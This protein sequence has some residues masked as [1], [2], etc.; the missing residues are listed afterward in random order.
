MPYWTD[1]HGRKW[2]ACSCLVEW[3]TAYQD[4]LLRQRLIRQC[5]DV[6]QLIGG[7]KA[8]A[9]SH[10]TGGCA[11]LGQRSREQLRV[12]RNMGAAAW[13]RD[14]DPDDG[15]PDFR[16]AHAHLSLKG[17]PHAQQYAKDQVD[18]LE[19]GFNGLG[20]LEDHRGAPD[21]GPRSGVQWPLRTWR[22]GIAWAKAQASPAPPPSPRPSKITLS[23]PRITEAS[24]LAASVKHPGNAYTLNDEN[25]LVFLVNT[26]TGKTVGTFRL[27]ATLRD[28][29]A[30]A[31]RGDG[32]LWVA[33][34]G[35]NDAKRK[36]CAL[37]VLAEPGPGNQGERHAERYA[38]AYPN[39]PRNAEA[40]CIN[41]VTKNRYI[42]SKEASGNLYRSKVGDLAL[43]KVNVLEHVGRK[44]PAYVTDACF[45]DDGRFVL[46]RQKDKPD[47][48]AV[49][50]GDSWRKVGT[51]PVPPLAKPESITVE[52][53]GLH[54]LIG[55]EG[56]NSPV[57]RVALPEAYRPKGEPAGAGVL[58]LSKFKRTLP[59]GRKDHPTELYPL[60]DTTG[61]VTFR[62]TVDGVT[63]KKTR[64]ARDELR[65]KHPESWSV[66]DGKHHVLSGR[67]RVTEIP[68]RKTS[69][70]TTGVVFGQ[71]H[72][73][74]DD[75]VILLVDI[76][77][78]VIVEEGL[79]KGNG[80][81]DTVLFTGY[82]LGDPLDY[83]IDAHRG[84]IDV[85][86][87]GHTVHLD[88]IAEDAYSKAGCYLRGNASNATG[89][90][91][92]DYDRLET[93]HA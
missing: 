24:G 88:A 43:G 62:A 59:T 9:G 1:F 28:P 30:L 58:E 20:Q 32:V 39:G 44:L 61:P 84:G 23:D 25:G 11:D 34:I 71:M 56:K 69:K 49:L 38:I 92:V 65:E 47:T 10:L 89:A 37:Y 12:A 27:K 74:S 31:V 41:P 40:F 72:D 55:T 51:I 70:Y 78:R 4:E 5:L 76:D 3:L 85:T 14:A 82:R 67:C 6:F 86:V 64:Y 75:I 17:C 63:T 26:T 93:R 79:G 22:E 7:A 16:P 35:D 90:G 77:G 81:D 91:A 42:I 48:V 36:D 54:F 87:N 68:G 53:D 8:S 18:D 33:D 45:T 73:G 21:D 60:A 83:V 66:R 80:S 57:Y 13:E 2:P 50:D 29:E 15:Q 52:E 19:D 46:V